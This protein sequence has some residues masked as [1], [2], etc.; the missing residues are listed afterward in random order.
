MYLPEHGVDG[1][2]GGACLLVVGELG[3]ELLHPAAALVDQLEGELG[4]VEGEAAPD[5]DPEGGCNEN[6]SDIRSII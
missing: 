3:D 4:V 6:K 1:G 5:L 2:V